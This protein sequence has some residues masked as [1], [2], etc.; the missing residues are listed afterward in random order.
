VIEGLRRGKPLF[1]SHFALSYLYNMQLA[2]AHP[3]DK[4][5]TRWWDGVLVGVMV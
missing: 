1:T 2:Q 4:I 5:K 3:R